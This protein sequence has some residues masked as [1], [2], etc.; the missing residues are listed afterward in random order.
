MTKRIPMSQEGRRRAA[1]KKRRLETAGKVAIV[2]MAAL[3]LV[4][5]LIM[6]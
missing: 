4:L 3:T 6:L 5:V 2:A 1:L